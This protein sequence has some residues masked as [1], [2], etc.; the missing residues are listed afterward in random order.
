MSRSIE[1]TGESIVY[2]F[3]AATLGI[4]AVVLYFVVWPVDDLTSVLLLVLS[5]ALVLFVVGD[6]L[7][8]KRGGLGDR[9]GSA[10]EGN[11]LY[12]ITYDPYA[13]PGQAAKDSWRKAV[14]RLPG[15]EDE[16]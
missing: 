4:A 1:V 3:Y 8:W 16:D 9:L 15:G 5:A 14:E 7:N 10:G 11:S 13:D 12:D 2:L 6:F